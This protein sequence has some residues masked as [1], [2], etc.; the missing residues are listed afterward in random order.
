[1]NQSMSSMK[2]ISATKT[3]NSTNACICS[4][5]RVGK[6]IKINILAAQ[7]KKIIIL[8]IYVHKLSFTFKC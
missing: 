1:M 6:P 5:Y 7:G 3:L 4:H 2:P 8:L